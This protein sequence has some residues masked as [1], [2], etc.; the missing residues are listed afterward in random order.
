MLEDEVPEIFD[1]SCEEIWT[2][3]M[4]KIFRYGTCPICTRYLNFSGS[5]PVSSWARVSLTYRQ[6]LPYQKG[7]QDSLKNLIILCRFC[8]T[9]CQSKRLDP[10][11]YAYLFYPQ[12]NYA[13]EWQKI[14]RK[15]DRCC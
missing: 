10:R 2:Y 13:K 7:C 15:R 1:P 12:S 14:K 3:R 6:H 4:T 5:N 11:E 9:K 8:A